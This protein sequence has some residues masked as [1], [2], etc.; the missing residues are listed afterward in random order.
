MRRLCDNLHEVSNVESNFESNVESD[1][2]TN[3]NDSRDQ[4]SCPGRDELRDGV[5]VGF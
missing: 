4:T 2:H 5:A 1:V 3:N